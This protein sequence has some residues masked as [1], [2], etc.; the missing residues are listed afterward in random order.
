MQ[1]VSAFRRGTLAAALVVA[2][3]GFTSAFAQS[4]APA[5]GTAATQTQP[6]TGVYSGAADAA[7]KQG[8]EGC[9]STAGA[10]QAQS[11]Q[12]LA[13]ALKNSTPSPYDNKANGAAKNAMATCGGQ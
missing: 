7:A 5:S 3:I 9:Q 4:Q 12:Q 11:P 2:S 10:L 6:A 13:Q 1:I 8:P